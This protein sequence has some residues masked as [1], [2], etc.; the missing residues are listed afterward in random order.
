MRSQMVDLMIESHLGG[1]I[2]IQHSSDGFKSVAWVSLML[3]H[4]LGIIQA[5]FPLKALL[6]YDRVLGKF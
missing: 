2:D 1:C 4:S 6:H 5:T 3:R